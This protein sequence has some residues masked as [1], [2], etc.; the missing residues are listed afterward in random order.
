MYPT[1]PLPFPNSDPYSALSEHHS[2]PQTQHVEALN[3]LATVEVAAQTAG[4]RHALL[5]ITQDT[6]TSVS[7]L[8]DKQLTIKLMLGNEHTEYKP[9]QFYP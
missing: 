7:A 4:K 6:V 9:T 8:L 5:C 2:K 3:T 1:L